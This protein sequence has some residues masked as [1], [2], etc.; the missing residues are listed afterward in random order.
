MFI[1]QAMEKKYPF[2]FFYMWLK[3]AKSEKKSGQI[4]VLAAKLPV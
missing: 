4:S 1:R 2:C 3:L